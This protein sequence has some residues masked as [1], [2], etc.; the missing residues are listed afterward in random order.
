[1]EEQASDEDIVG[2]DVDLSLG[3]I[4]SAPE[5]ITVGIGGQPGDNDVVVFECKP[6]GE[7]RFV[8]HDWAGKG[9]TR[10]KFVEVQSSVDLAVRRK[11]VGG[12]EAEAVVTHSRAKSNDAAGGLSIFDRIASCLYIDRANSIG[13][14]AQRHS[15][16][17][18]RAHTKELQDTQE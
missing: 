10:Y 6:V 18:W 16:P 11:E 12:V 1:M 15:P 7:P 14:Y 13:A 2:S 17:S 4:A 9:Y 3:Q 8:L 5:L